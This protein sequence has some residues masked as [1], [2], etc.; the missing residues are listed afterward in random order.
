MN[1]AL[2]CQV[3]LKKI[4]ENGERGKDGCQRMTILTE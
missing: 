4:L 2:I 1:L 3:A